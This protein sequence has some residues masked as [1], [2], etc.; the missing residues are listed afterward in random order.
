MLL[1]LISRGVKF[2]FFLKSNEVYEQFK[3]KKNININSVNLRVV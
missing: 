1:M 2:L 3:T